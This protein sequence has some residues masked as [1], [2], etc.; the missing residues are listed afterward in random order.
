MIGG[1]NY[2]HYIDDPDKK[3]PI[4]FGSFLEFLNIFSGVSGGSRNVWNN[5]IRKDDNINSRPTIPS[6][7]N[8]ALLRLLKKFG[9]NRRK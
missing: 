7:T 1:F 5:E 6:D 4:G 8:G 9:K 2:M 3:P